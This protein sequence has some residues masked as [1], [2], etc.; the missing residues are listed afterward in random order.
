[1]KGSI[2]K[3]DLRRDGE[4]NDGWEGAGERGGR[5][6]DYGEKIVGA[7]LGREKYTSE[8]FKANG[9]SRLKTPLSSRALN[10]NVPPSGVELTGWE[11]GMW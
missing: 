6:D 4:E 9:N 1:M 10:S 5:A 7:G 2:C 11:A 3:R 8:K